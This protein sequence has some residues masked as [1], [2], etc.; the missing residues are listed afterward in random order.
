MCVNIQ[1]VML[2]M[3]IVVVDALCVLSSM[4]NSYQ[5]LQLHLLPQ[6]GHLLDNMY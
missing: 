6:M 5:L 4:N 1:I 2:Y 3:P